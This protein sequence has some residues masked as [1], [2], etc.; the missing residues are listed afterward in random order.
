MWGATQLSRQIIQLNLSFNSRTPCG[1]RRL[2]NIIRHQG[3]AVSIHAPRVGCDAIRGRELIGILNVSIHAPRVGCDLLGHRLPAQRLVSIH[4]P[5]VGC[6]L[7]AD[8][9]IDQRVLFQFTHPVWGATEQY[10]LLSHKI[11]LFQFTHPV[12]GAT[13]Q[14][15]VAN[16][17]YQ[18]QFT[19][20]VW[21]ATSGQFNRFMS[22]IVSIHAPRVGCDSIYNPIQRPTKAFQFTHPVWGATSRPSI[23]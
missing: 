5:R 4:A 15:D 21:G 12:W 10:L 7:I 14:Q 13:N 3:G 8:G 17:P 1:V 18:F 11:H 16:Q 19:H 2:S 22:I 9:T 6:D 20:P 23:S